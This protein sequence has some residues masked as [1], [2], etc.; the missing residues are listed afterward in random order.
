MYLKA[1]INNSHH[2]CGAI[3]SQSGDIIPDS[4]M[5]EGNYTIITKDTF[6]YKKK[7]NFDE[8][9]I[10]NSLHNK[11]SIYLKICFNHHGHILCNV[12]PSMFHWFDLKYK[13]C[14][15]I[16]VNYG[17]GNSWW[18]NHHC[19]SVINELKKISGYKQNDIILHEK[20]DTLLSSKYF[21]AK[22][23]L[24]SILRKETD[25][26]KKILFVKN[27]ILNNIDIESPIKQKK[28]FLGRDPNIIRSDPELYQETLNF[29]QKQGFRNIML[30][31][32]SFSE[33]ISIMQN[34]DIV[35]GFSGSQLHNSIF[36]KP[37]TMCINIGDTKRD[38]VYKPFENA[39]S[40][41]TYPYIQ[42]DFCDIENRHS[43]IGTKGLSWSNIAK[44]F[45]NILKE[46]NK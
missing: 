43:Y 11:E 41:D 19:T 2:N 12:I 32:Y 22:E 16:Y 44:K 15:K 13:N 37:N 17:K 28:L 25:S 40:N 9:V 29:F 21:S 4:K 30:R 39:S 27:K 23:I 35:A 3:Y 14:P 10:D 34:A 38:G 26:I 45:I 46:G 18:A 5:E 6:K 8:Y 31:K 42:R 24:N 7:I 36:C 20:H 33:Q 1:T